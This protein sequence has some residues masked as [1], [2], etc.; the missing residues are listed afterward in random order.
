VQPHR[1]RLRRLQIRLQPVCII[2]GILLPELYGS[3]AS[4]ALPHLHEC[5]LSNARHASVELVSLP[6]VKRSHPCSQLHPARVPCRR[7]PHDRHQSCMLHWAAFNSRFNWRVANRDSQVKQSHLACLPLVPPWLSDAPTRPSCRPTPS[8]HWY[9]SRRR[10][11]QSGR[12][13]YHAQPAKRLWKPTCQHHGTPA[14]PC[15]CMAV[16]LMLEESLM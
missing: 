13:R 7:M 3:I 14:S 15:K 9:K 1:W 16:V 2:N 6:L 12:S 11:A 10:L 5:Q 8:G 4:R